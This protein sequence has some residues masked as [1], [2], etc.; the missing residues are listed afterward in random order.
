MSEKSS[1]E[2]LSDLVGATQLGNRAY[3][4]GEEMRAATILTAFVICP[5]PVMTQD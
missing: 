3:S 4:G 1:Y 5:S 2:S